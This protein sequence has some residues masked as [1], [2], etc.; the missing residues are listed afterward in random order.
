MCSVPLRLMFPKI[1]SICRNQ[2]CVVRDCWADGH[3]QVDVRRNISD[4]FMDEWRELHLTLQ[5]VNLDDQQD[6]AVWVLESSGKYSCKSMYRHLSFSGV[7]LPR[8]QKFWKTKLPLKV[9]V[10]L[11]LAMKD[12]IQSG[13]QLKKKNWKGERNCVLCRVPETTDHILFN[14]HSARFVWS[15]IGEAFE[16][17]RVPSNMQDFQENWLPINSKNFELMH[18]CFGVIAWNLWKNRN[19][20]AIEKKFDKST[21]AILFKIVNDMQR[22]KVLLKSKELEALESK[23]AE[24]KSWFEKFKKAREK[25]V[26]GT[27]L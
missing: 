2:K 18:F 25:D 22:W 24:A 4:F 12:R 19:K 17:D 10:F 21:D 7:K 15:C 9:K 11:R 13:V 23:L 3:W 6:K 26:P 8:M 20:M 14:C 27:I 5:G 16:W 1:F